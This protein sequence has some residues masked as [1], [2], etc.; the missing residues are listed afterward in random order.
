MFGSLFVIIA[1]VVLL[2]G[3]N[4][5]YV[6]AEFSSISARRPRLAQLADEGNA[7]ARYMLSIVENPKTLDIHISACQ[8]GITL[9]S[10]LLGFYGQAQ[11]IALLQPQ[12]EKLSPNQEVIVTSAL[13]IV[14]LLI[15]TVFQVVLGELMPKSVALQHPEQLAVATAPALRWSGAIFR[16]LIFL[17]NGSAQL[18]LRL[19]GMGAAGEHSH[20]HS[21]EEILILVEESSAGGVLDEEERRLLV[22]TL[23]LRKLTARKVMI[24]RIYMLMAPIDKSCDELFE[25]LAASPYSRLPLYEESVDTIVGVIHLKD[26]IQIFFDREQKRTK[27]DEPTRAPNHAS[28]DPYSRF[29][30][31]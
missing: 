11:I 18:L 16:P 23:Q 5:L 13:S 19:L 1:V 8:L 14:V 24:P 9:S 28:G 26:L 22:N 15:L 21:P 2:I 10:L 17:F 3:V 30:T 4:G 31:G 29:S 12:L 25:L 20:L 6:A 7:S 27:L